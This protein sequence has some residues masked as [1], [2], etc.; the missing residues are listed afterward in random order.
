MDEGNIDISNSVT[1]PNSNINL[2]MNKKADDILPKEEE[3]FSVEEDN[4]NYKNIK[5]PLYHN[6]NN[7]NMHFNQNY[8]LLENQPYLLNEERMNNFNENFN[9]S[10]Y[11]EQ[12]K[13]FDKNY[14]Y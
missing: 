4:N 1:R 12:I 5:E 11:Q 14:I 13:F 9:A 10:K 7:I 2:L 3:L 8:D 6:D